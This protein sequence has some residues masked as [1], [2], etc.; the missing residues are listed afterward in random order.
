MYLYRPYKEF[1]TT[2]VLPHQMVPISAVA[3]G[4]QCMQYWCTT[5]D[6]VRH[7]ISY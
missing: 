1:S 7:M 5:P 3:Q 2:K 4:L 6:D